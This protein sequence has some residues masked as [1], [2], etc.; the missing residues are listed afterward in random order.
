MEN[1]TRDVPNITTLVQHKRL[2]WIETSLNIFGIGK[3]SIE[4]KQDPISR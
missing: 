1:K 4:T 2:I 3:I